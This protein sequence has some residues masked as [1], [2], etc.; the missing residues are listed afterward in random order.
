VGTWLRGRFRRSDDPAPALPPA[1]TP[2][3]D[4]SD[5]P[6]VVP[7]PK[8]SALEQLR[9][10]TAIATQSVGGGSAT[11]Y[12]MRRTLIVRH[13]WLTDY[14]FLEDWTLSRISPG[15]TLIAL[16]ALLG[17]RL[18]GWPGVAYAIGGMLVPAAFIA[19][20]L[21]ATLVEV[22]SIPAVLAAL[23][24]MGP[25]TIGMMLG[26]TVTL[27]R[28]AVRKQGRRRF[29]DLTLVA[30]AVAVGFVA[31]LSPVAMILAGGVVGA[32]FLGEGPAP[33]TPADS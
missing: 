31:P 32:L 6:P 17:R 16:T 21:T 23:S 8:L 33:E 3:A 30:V 25:V 22:E 20:V 5:E 13:R 19:A 1:G 4:A 7:V 18:G 29:A 28:S 12:L 15:V 10:W 14:E 9:F 24:G 26:L 27:A 11:L 2:E